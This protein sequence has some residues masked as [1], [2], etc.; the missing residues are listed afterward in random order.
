MLYRKWKDSLAESKGKVDE[1]KRKHDRELKDINI[2]L[3]FIKETQSKTNLKLSNSNRIIEE[4]DVKIRQLETDMKSIN[5]LLS[6]AKQSQK[7]SKFDSYDFNNILKINSWVRFP[8]LI[9]SFRIYCI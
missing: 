2:E 1:L 7:N 5:K 8:K 4:K 6:E 3:D 9:F